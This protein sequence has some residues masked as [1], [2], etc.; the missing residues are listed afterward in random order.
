MIASHRLGLSLVTLLLA[1]RPSPDRATG[2]RTP[3]G[4]QANAAGSA[5]LLAE[6][7]D[8][9]DPGEQPP[10]FQNAPPVVVEITA[11]GNAVEAATLEAPLEAWE[12]LP[13]SASNN[14]R[15]V[16]IIQLARGLLTAESA[17]VR[18]DHDRVVRLR[19][20]ERLY[21]F[22]D[23]PMFVNDR[24]F[25]AA[26]FGQAAKVATAGKGQGTDEARAMELVSFAFDAMKRAGALHLH[27]AAVLMREHPGDRHVPDVLDRVA[28]SVAGEQPE[29]A[30]RLRNLGVELRG[31][32][33][34]AA[35][36]LEQAR[37]C[38]IAFDSGCGDPALARGKS[39]AAAADAALAK[40]IAEVETVRE[41]AA[42]VRANEQATALEPRLERAQLLVELGRQRDAASTLKAL[43]AE[44]PDD[45][46]VVTTA[47]RQVMSD[48]FDLEGA[49]RVIASAPAKLQHRDRAYLE[50]AIGLRATH[51]AYEV[52]PRVRGSIAEM[53]T[54]IAPEYA[55]LK[56]D[57]LE[58]EA[59][60]A[61]LGKVI[62]TLVEIGEAALP[63][64]DGKS[65]RE[66]LAFARRQLPK[67]LAL[68]GRAPESPEAWRLTS[69]LALLSEDR[70]KVL[71]FADRP[72]PPDADGT[73]ALQHAQL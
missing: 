19:A 37:S 2:T 15:T 64:A 7:A 48:K 67:G 55:L 41:Q 51:F 36:L 30:V 71:S 60:G 68:Q 70:A 56:A 52:M 20:L 73:L 43:L 53:M 63:F 59:G 42:K 39:K 31:E 54:T 26:V 1:C 17:R 69:G 32:Y 21:G 12:T 18:D 9:I 34:T 5:A 28:R 49:Y 40:Q 62:R 25:F 13:A 14:A 65:D 38:Y 4:T 6:L 33:V 24:S 45:A 22:F 27:T 58:Y 11:P 72:V 57:I 66:L 46:R 44:F 10:L 50:A 35:Q 16:A 3:G 23:Q 29:L 47:A 8:A 61:D